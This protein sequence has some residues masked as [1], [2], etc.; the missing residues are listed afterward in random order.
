MIARSGDWSCV[1]SQ[2][3]SLSNSICAGGL[4]LIHQPS[5][6]RAQSALRIS[7]LVDSGVKI[8]GFRQRTAARSQ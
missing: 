5:N 4:L 6:G 2:Y 1:F 3:P 8:D 7:M